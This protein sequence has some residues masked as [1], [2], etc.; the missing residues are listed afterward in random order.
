MFI[1]L[2]RRVCNVF[3]CSWSSATTTTNSGDVVGAAFT[4]PALPDF[5][6]FLLVSGNLMQPRLP[7]KDQGKAPSVPQ[8]SRVRHRHHRCLGGVSQ[9]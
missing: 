6:R 2:L 1:I 4:V 3:F 7:E 8:T 5:P 9:S